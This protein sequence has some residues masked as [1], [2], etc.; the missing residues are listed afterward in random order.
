MRKS[1]KIVCT[2][3]P[4][5]Q[6]EDT[7]G[8]LAAEGMNV[9]RMNLSH[10]DHRFHGRT[11]ETARKVARQAG[12]PVGILLDLQGPKIRTGKLDKEE[13]V[14]RAGDRIIL[15]P[16]EKTGTWE[17]LSVNYP[18]LPAET[19]VGERIYLDD[20]NI[21]LKVTAIR[22]NAVV[23]SVV[24][25]G[26]IRSYRGVNLP[27]T[28]VSAPAL[29]DKDLEDLAFGLDMGVDFV[30]LS[31]VRRPEDIVDLRNRMEIRGAKAAVVAKIEKPEA[32]RNIGGIIAVSDAVMIA[33]GDLGA[34]TS[35][36]DV[37]IYQKMIIDR[38][39]RAG[40]PVITATQMLESMTSNPR[41]T[42]AEASDVANAIFDGTDAVMLSQETALGEYPVEAVRI[43]THI[44]LSAEEEMRKGTIPL[45]D[46]GTPPKGGDVADAVCRTACSLSDIVEPRLIVGFTL[47]GRTAALVSKYR[48][49]VPIIAMSP[50]QE[51]LGRLSLFWGVHGVEIETID[52]AE[53][54]I[55]RAE[56]LLLKRGFCGEN[57]RVIIVGGVPVLAGEP[58]NM[59]KVH[60]VN[61]AEKAI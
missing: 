60:R 9:V 5:S 7:M 2:I 57:D 15:T 53:A 35:P 44:A 39:R 22:E 18:R 59:V 51:V 41:P 46:R 3:G 45:K 25:G 55:S 34:E 27:D 30:A 33:R 29:T 36:Q 48:P 14:L 43:M 28:K 49:P 47:S 6:S 12:G 54:L 16:E 8:M 31:F 4:K 23:C 42:R 1:T 10:G 52:T 58:T 40:K 20:G 32:V 26:L 17:E 24:N 37:P 50:V 56:E 19:R 11:V 13:V 38:C 21:E 61:L